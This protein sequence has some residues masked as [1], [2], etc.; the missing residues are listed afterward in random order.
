[1]AAVTPAL[2][3]VMWTV[4]GLPDTRYF[5]PWY[6]AKERELK[7]AESRLHGA[8]AQV[9]DLQARLNDAVNQRKQWESECNKLRKQVDALEKQLATAKKQLEE[10]TILR[11]DLE[12]RL[13]SLKEELAFSRQIHSQELNESRMRTTV[14][15]EEVDSRLQVDYEARLAEALQQMRE[16]N[17]AQIRATRGEAETYFQRK[18]SQLKAMAMAKDGTSESARKELNESR[19]RIEELESQLLKVSG[20]I[21]QNEAQVRELEALLKRDRAEHEDVLNMRDLEIRRL[22]EA[23]EDQMTEYRDLLDIKIQL[24]LELVAYRKLLEGEE[25]RRVVESVSLLV[26]CGLCHHSRVKSVSLLVSCGLCH[27]C[28]VIESVYC[29]LVVSVIAVESVSLLVSCGLCHHSR[30]SVKRRISTSCQWSSQLSVLRLNITTE[31]TP[32]KTPRRS[33]PLGSRKRKRMTVTHQGAGDYSHL[34][35]SSSS[36]FNAT[37]SA[38]G[39]V[40]ISEVDPAGQFIKIHNTSDKDVPVG[41]WQLKH[42]A[43]DEETTYKYHRS[44]QIK[45]GAI[46]TVWSSESDQTHSPPSDLVMK[47]QKWFVADNMRTVLLNNQGDRA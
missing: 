36:A 20:Q 8:E 21:A 23:I 41:S 2:P 16:E 5:D 22:R 17:D 38:T 31:G 27:H 9:N 10:E 13:Q 30:V 47:G 25:S 6:T 24:D 29:C 45:A 19:R 34:Q 26:S 28:R 42:I 46:I 1:M 43:N 33:T 18:L 14:E 12:N 11:V 3:P 7:T 15:V 39:A 44:I 32:G 4:L 35:S 40:E 37:S